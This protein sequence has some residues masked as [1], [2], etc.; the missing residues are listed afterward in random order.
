L[1]ASG[2]VG[3]GPMGRSPAPVC[4]N[5]VVM[6]DN[7]LSPA[8]VARLRA[9][10]EL[11]RLEGVREG[12]RTAVRNAV[13]VELLLRTGLRVSAL[14]ALRTG[15][16]YLRDGRADVLVRR[17]KGGKA[18]MVAISERLAEYLRRYLDGLVLN[19]PLFV[20][21]RRGHLTRSAVHRV[22]KAAL[23][24]GGLSTSWGVHATRHSYARRGVSTHARPAAHPAA[25]RTCQRRDND[26]VRELA[27][28]GRAA[29]G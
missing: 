17:G 7:F 25:A 18:R 23:D 5:W 1:I 29:R 2:L 27:R 16:L 11:S 24:R 14:C 8:Q 10:V 19:G 22:W 6:P 20:S 9:S 13:I 3:I 4:T 21:E 12:A 28:R 15:D 26:R